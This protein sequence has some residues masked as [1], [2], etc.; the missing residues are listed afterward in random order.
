LNEAVD[1]MERCLYAKA[2][3]RPFKEE[4]GDEGFNEEE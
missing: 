4:A 1:T 2:T 3:G